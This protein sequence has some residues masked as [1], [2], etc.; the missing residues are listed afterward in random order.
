MPMNYYFISNDGEHLTIQD[1]YTWR[2]HI[3]I[4]IENV[5]YLLQ[6]PSSTFTLFLWFPEFQCNKHLVLYISS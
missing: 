6:Y 1:L 3:F 2:K 4:V 5:M